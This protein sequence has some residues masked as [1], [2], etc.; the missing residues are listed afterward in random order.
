MEVRLDEI[1]I[2]CVK[3]STYL[4]QLVGSLDGGCLFS[5]QMQSIYVFHQI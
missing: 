4:I 5:N 3:L 2:K 1:E